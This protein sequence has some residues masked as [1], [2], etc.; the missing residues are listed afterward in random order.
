M[1]RLELIP[2]GAIVGRNSLKK[3]ALLKK[4]RKKSAKEK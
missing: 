2:N 4:N 1:R 3:P